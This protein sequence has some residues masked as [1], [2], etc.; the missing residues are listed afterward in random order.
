MDLS[1]ALRE[2]NSQVQ[3]NVPIMVTADEI[4]SVVSLF[5]TA[6]DA[7]AGSTA[8]LAA[9][10]TQLASLQGSV[11]DLNDPALE[12]SLKDVLAKAAA[13]NVPPGNVTPLPDPNAGGG[14]G[15]PPAG[16]PVTDGGAPAPTA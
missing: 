1:Q 13:A 12:Q 10:S 14:A 8:A 2:I 9:L 6:L 15:T 4:K 3:N 5:N 7:Q 11:A 16:A